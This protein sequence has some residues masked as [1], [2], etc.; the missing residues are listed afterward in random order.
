MWLRCRR[1]SSYEVQRNE[2][3]KSGPDYEYWK[4]HRRDWKCGYHRFGTF[5]IW[6]VDLEKLSV[7]TLSDIWNE[8]YAIEVDL[9]YNVAAEFVA[10]ERIDR[11]HL[12]MWGWKQGGIIC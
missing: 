12:R 8:L 3:D 10:A 4:F 5:K 6:G 7:D 9:R 2:T 11:L 1:N